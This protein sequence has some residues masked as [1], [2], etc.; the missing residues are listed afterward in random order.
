MKRKDCKGCQ[1]YSREEDR[2]G[3]FICRKYQKP[4]KEIEIC[5][6]DELIEE[7]QEINKQISRL[8][9]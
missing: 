4:S 6:E 3:K 7:M 9:R 5:K 8:F 2:K 1:H